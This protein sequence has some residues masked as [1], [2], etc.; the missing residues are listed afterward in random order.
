MKKLT[1]KFVVVYDTDNLIITKSET[2]A[3]TYVPKDRLSAEF[4]TQE[5]LDSFITD[6]NLHEYEFETED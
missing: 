4:D 6:N 3:E 2:N 1:K 5:E